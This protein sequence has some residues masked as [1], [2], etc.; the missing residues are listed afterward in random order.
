MKY[1]QRDIVLIDFYDGRHWKERPALVVSNDDLQEA[2]NIVYVAMISTKE[3]NP[4]YCYRITPEMY[5]GTLDKQSFV[6]C[7]II[8]FDTTTGIIKKIGRFKEE[9]FDEIVDKVINSIF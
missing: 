2:E 8:E 3:F 9:Y 6:K 5:T 4:Q 7:H 1:T